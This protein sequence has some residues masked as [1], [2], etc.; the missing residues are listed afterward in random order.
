M[1]WLDLSG[2][3]VTKL[4]QDDL[5]QPELRGLRRLDLSHNKL[6]GQLKEG[7]FVTLPELRVSSR[8]CV[9]VCVCVC[10]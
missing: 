5:D 6:K 4:G 10:V 7:T 3:D 1:V 9:F 8:M 2:N